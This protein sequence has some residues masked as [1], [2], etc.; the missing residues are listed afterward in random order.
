MRY[1]LIVFATLAVLAAACAQD[2]PHPGWQPEPGD[3]DP[4]QNLALGK[5]YEYA[6]PKASKK[7]KVLVCLKNSKE[8]A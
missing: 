1:A 7:K 2:E 6:S 4:A 5:E 3:L 8:K